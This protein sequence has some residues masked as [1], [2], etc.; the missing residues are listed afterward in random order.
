VL[1]SEA[2]K[3]LE[4]TNPGNCTQILRIVVTGLIESVWYR[5]F[6]G[7]FLRNLRDRCYRVLS[8]A[9]WPLPIAL[10]FHG[11]GRRK[12]QARDCKEIIQSLISWSRKF[13][14][15]LPSCS[16]GLLFTSVTLKRTYLISNSRTN[17]KATINHPIELKG[18]FTQLLCGCP[19]GTSIRLLWSKLRTS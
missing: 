3:I 16:R 2:Y 6:R 15:E 5:H 9:A 4:K 11:S 1:D 17:M 18:P 13:A 19:W 8:D 14:I 12:N 10:R 7:Y